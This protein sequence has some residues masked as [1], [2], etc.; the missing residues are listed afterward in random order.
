MHEEHL[1]NICIVGPVHV[2]GIWLTP[3]PASVR[4]NSIAGAPEVVWC[5]AYQQHRRGQKANGKELGYNLHCSSFYP[6][7]ISHPLA[8]VEIQSCSPAFVCWW[9]VCVRFV[10]AGS[11]C[12]SICYSCDITQGP[13]GTSRTHP[14]TAD[15]TCSLMLFDY[16]TIFFPFAWSSSFPFSILLTTFLALVCVCQC[17]YVCMCVCAVL[18]VGERN[19]AK[20]ELKLYWKLH[21]C[22]TGT[23]CYS[24][25]LYK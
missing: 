13:A 14:P 17:V 5:V 15:V 16:L 24:P 2:C 4:E 22:S 12:P 3:L 21:H 23:W 9:L 6:V 10:L 20:T 18:K 8:S 25:F 11:G 7:N 19:A 1:Y